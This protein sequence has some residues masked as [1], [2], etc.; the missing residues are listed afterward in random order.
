MLSLPLR[1]VFAKTSAHASALLGRAH[2]PQDQSDSRWIIRIE[3]ESGQ[4]RVQRRR[5]DPHPTMNLRAVKGQ[6]ADEE[7]ADGTESR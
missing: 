3:S 2:E 7:V 1:E 5:Y 4:G 6:M